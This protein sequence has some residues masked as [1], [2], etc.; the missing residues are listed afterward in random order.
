MPIFYALVA[1]GKTVLAEFTARSGNFPT[2]TRVLLGKINE[3]TDAKMSYMYDEYVFH[4][5]VD[6][7]ITYLC[8]AD[9]KQKR[10][11][12]FMFL[13]DIKE[14][15]NIAAGAYLNRLRFPVRA[16]NLIS[17]AAPLLG[18]LGTIVG[19]VIVFEGV[20]GAGAAHRAPVRRRSHDRDD[21]RLGVADARRRAVRYA[22][23]GREDPGMREPSRLA[24]ASRSVL[25]GDQAWRRAEARTDPPGDLVAIQPR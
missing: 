18:L 22:S 24:A 25:D 19:M 20:A 14:R 2:V 12:P 23:G 13:E 11:I 6:A 5:M 16:L 4:Y 17:V 15:A 10:R 8:L 1:R 7:G 3:A 21:R 9:E